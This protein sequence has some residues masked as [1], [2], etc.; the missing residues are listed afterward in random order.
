MKNRIIAATAGL[1]VAVGGFALG[2]GTAPDPVEC[3]AALD[4]ADAAVAVLAVPN[5][6]HVER[7]QRYGEIDYP[8][9]RDAC[10]EA[11]R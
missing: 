2:R 4:A 10:R 7:G 5:L 3:L 9:H 1:A 6:D 8:T 11:I